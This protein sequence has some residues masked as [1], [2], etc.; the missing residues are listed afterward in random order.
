MKRVHE[1]QCDLMWPNFCHFGDILSPWGFLNVH[2]LLG[3]I[4]DLLWQTFEAIGYIVTVVNG[5]TLNK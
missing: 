1:G 3:N 4:L 5:L 2:L